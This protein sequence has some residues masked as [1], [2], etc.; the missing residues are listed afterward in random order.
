MYGPE[1]AILLM[2]GSHDMRLT[3]FRRLTVVHGTPGFWDV[4]HAFHDCFAYNQNISCLARS[5]I[6]G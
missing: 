5:Y 4:T 3:S 6:M 2:Y 1:W